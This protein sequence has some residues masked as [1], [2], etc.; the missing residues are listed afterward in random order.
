MLARGR[1]VFGAVLIVLATHATAQ[2]DQ[3]RSLAVCSPDAKNVITLELAPD[4]QGGAPRFAVARNGRQLI[5]PSN[6]GMRLAELGS[7]ADEPSLAGVERGQTDERFELPWGKCRA[8]RDQCQWLRATLV[9]HG[10][11]W[12]IEARAYDDGVA[13]RYA[14]PN[15][16]QP[17]D[18]VVEAEETQFRLAGAPTI[19]FMTCKNFRTDHEN[20]YQRLP[21]AEVPTNTLIDLPLL[22]VWPDAAA[23]ITEARVR[24]FPHLYLERQPRAAAWQCRLSPLP[25]REGV[26]A[27]GQ[28]PLWSPWRVVLLSDRAGPLLESSLLLCL[29][30][31][32]PETDFTWARPGKTT[33]H[34]WNGTAERELGFPCGMN[35]ATHKRYIDFCARHKIAYHAVVADDRPWYV[36]SRADFAPGPDTDI[37]TPRPELELPRILDYARQ[38]DVGIRLWV[39]WKPLDERLEEAFARYQAWGVRGLMVDFLNRDDQDM[40]NFCQRVLASAARHRLHIQFHGSHK[41]SG[42]QRTF[43]H[44]FNREGVLNLEYL[45]WSA[46]CTPPHNVGV[47]YTRLLAGPLDYHLG[48]FRAAPREQFQ[49]RNENPQVLGTRCHHLAMY[50]VYENP[51]PMVCD[52]PSAYE[53]QMGF[54][55]LTAVPTTW[56]QTRFVAGEPGEYVVMARRKGDR[57]Y[58]GGMTNWTGRELGIPLDFLGEGKYRLVLYTDGS[59]NESEP[60]AINRQQREATAATTL[61]VGLAPGGG[62]VA[63]VEPP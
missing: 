13:F 7:I 24:D 54:D 53:G 18:L 59:L 34:W 42:E 6:L 20:E 11:K 51:M 38:N 19:H 40:V 49:P 37:L 22:A 4:N 41:P 60:N 29:N 43:P 26:C 35:F 5:E 45:K 28:T 61:H 33:W 25:S 31:P 2:G 46:R 44:L 14:F 12:E 21:L 3:R 17:N 57:W 62:F 58:V 56:D 30:D 10:I 9:S 36:Q 23:A 32:P 39:H 63:A 48:G 15:Q 47:A 8:V 52:A 1:A 55:F 27:V 16:P 50:V